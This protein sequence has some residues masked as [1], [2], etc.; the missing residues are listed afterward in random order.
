M[1]GYCIYPSYSVLGHSQTA[2]LRHRITRAP[3]GSAAFDVISEQQ[4]HGIVLDRM[5][6]SK[7]NISSGLLHYED[8]GTPA[9]LTFGPKDLSVRALPPNCSPPGHSEGCTQRA[10]KALFPESFRLCI[11]EVQPGICFCLPCL[12]HS[13]VQSAHRTTEPVAVDFER[14]EIK[15]G[16]ERTFTMLATGNVQDQ[17]VNPKAQDH[18]TFRTCINPRAVKAAE[19]VGG[20][21]AQYAGL[22]RHLSPQRPLPCKA[23]CHL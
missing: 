1:G 13:S 15:K 16:R 2:C 14:C 8:S 12:L 21:A 3:K 18:V 10:L 4:Y 5:V 22:H 23:T 20:A 9:K 17:N 6:K 11:S 7:N 19:K